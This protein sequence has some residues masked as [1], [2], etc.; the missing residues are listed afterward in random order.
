MQTLPSLE[1]GSGEDKS[2]GGE[3][4]GQSTGRVIVS[5]HVTDRR[6]LERCLVPER[7]IQG[8]R[9]VVTA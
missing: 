5:N 6:T 2:T 4:G 7:G 8:S 1:D 9:N 3:G